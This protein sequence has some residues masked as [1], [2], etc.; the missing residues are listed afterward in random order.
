[1]QS[2]APKRVTIFSID[3]HTQVVPRSDPD[4]VLRQLW[5]IKEVC[6]LRE[7][8]FEPLDCDESWALDS[9]NP[10]EVLENRGPVQV[11]WDLELAE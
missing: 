2:H 9:C 1:M 8:A 6:C 3:T 11:A 5:W 7:S 10:L 4:R